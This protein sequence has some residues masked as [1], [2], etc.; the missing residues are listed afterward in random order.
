MSEM[1][2]EKKKDPLEIELWKP[3]KN[4]A[5]LLSSINE[6]PNM[7][8]IEKVMEVLNL[9]MSSENFIKSLEAKKRDY[10]FNDLFSA[11][12][13]NIYLHRKFES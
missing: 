11:V 8:E 13:K 5:D 1:Q 10:F 6:G 7:Q 12:V 2:E 3:V 4:K 9:F